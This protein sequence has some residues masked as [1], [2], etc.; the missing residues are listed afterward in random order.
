MWFPWSSSKESDSSPG[1]IGQQSIEERKLQQAEED[2]GH[3]RGAWGEL[4]QLSF[5]TYPVLGLGVSVIFFAG[6]TAHRRWDSVHSRYFKRIRRHYD[7]PDSWIREKRYLKG[8]ITGVPDGDGFLFLHTPGPGWQRPLKFRRLPKL[9]TSG[10]REVIRMRMAAIDAPEVGK[11]GAEGQPFSIES[12]DWL[13]SKVLDK[14]VYCQL[15]KREGLYGRIIVL[16]FLPRRF[17][18]WWLTGNRGTNLSEESVRQGWAFVYESES[19]EFPHPDKRAGY[20]SLMNEAQKAKVGIWKNGTS[21]E[22]P[23]QYKKRTKQGAVPEN[24]DDSVEASEEQDSWF[25]LKL[26]NVFRRP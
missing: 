4:S 8:K 24:A 15:L 12:R 20:L 6:W 19:G 3:L 17:P 21:L 9:K 16:P 25:G 26:N 13:R 1:R 5:G 14:T 22:T 2:V 10:A 7:V 11:G 23:G 18:P